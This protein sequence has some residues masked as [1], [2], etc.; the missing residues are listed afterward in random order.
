MQRNHFLTQIN[1]NY[2]IFL[3]QLLVYDRQCDTTK[4]CPTCCNFCIYPLGL[5]RIYVNEIRVV[6]SIS[7]TKKAY[8]NGHNGRNFHVLQFGKCHKHHNDTAASLSAKNTW[9]EHITF[10]NT[11]NSVK[12]RLWFPQESRQEISRANKETP[13]SQHTSFIHPTL[14]QGSQREGINLI[15]KEFAGWTEVFTHAYTTVFAHL[16]HILL[17]TAKRAYNLHHMGRV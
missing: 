12:S 5:L 3:S 16:L 8:H 7:V 10:C 1:K 17:M 13:L 11:Q 6:Q 4:V 15:I 2:P 9:D 14:N